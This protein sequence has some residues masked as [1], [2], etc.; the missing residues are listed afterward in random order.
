MEEIKNEN[1]RVAVV[2][3]G[4]YKGMVNKMDEV[5]GSLSN[6]LKFTSAQ[7]ASSYD[8]LVSLF[9]QE[10]ESLLSEFRYL[11]QQSSAIYDNSRK[12]RAALKAS[13]LDAVRAGNEKVAE[14]KTRLDEQLSALKDVIR[15][16]SD[17]IS[18]LEESVARLNH[19][20]DE[21]READEHIDYD[22][23]AE[24]IA[25]VL[26]ETDYD[27][28]V[29]RFTTAVPPADGDA[30]AAAV[31][32]AMPQTNEEA[33]AEKVAE[34]IPPVDYEALAA[35]VVAAMSKEETPEAPVAAENAAE[36]ADGY[37]VLRA[38]TVV[39]HGV[40]LENFVMEKP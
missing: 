33:L 24:K 40:A 16:E 30:I 9:R 6:E 17:R 28:L 39:R 12:D 37:R 36:T 21:P 20:G 38:Q 35:A 19:V 4:M 29:D 3:E 13:V 10:I 2:M 27:T 18:A 23:L 8:S 5:A 7:Q 22:V 11:T 1:K 34:N 15:A 32:A 25:S 26:P 14:L 31:V